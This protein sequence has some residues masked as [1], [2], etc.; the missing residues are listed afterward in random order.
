MGLAF[1]SGFASS[2]GQ[3][4]E[5]FNKQ[6]AETK[7]REA[8]IKKAEAEITAAENSN[9]LE[10]AKS[11]RTDMNKHIADQA[12][13]RKSDSKLS[14][15]ERLA[16]SNRI[17]KAALNRLDSAGKEAGKRGYTQYSTMYEEFASRGIFDELEEREG[18]L[19]TKEMAAEMDDGS[20]QINRAGDV[21]RPKLTTNSRG[22]VVEEVND[23]GGKV[24]EITS[25]KLVDKSKIFPE[26]VS[27]KDSTQLE[28][29]YTKYVARKGN[30]NV[31]F[32]DYKNKIYDPSS[33]TVYNPRELFKGDRKVKVYDDEQY[34]E[35]VNQGFSP[36]EESGSG[37]TVAQQ[38]LTDYSAYKKS[39]EI[40]GGT[41]MPFA[42]WES[43]QKASGESTV[44]RSEMGKIDTEIASIVGTSDISKVDLTQP[45][46]N[47]QRYTI[48][49][50]LRE[51]NEVIP[52]Y[53]KETIESLKGVK[54][55][56]GTL[57]KLTTS[58]VE[59]IT[60]LVDNLWSNISEFTGIG[61]AEDFASLKAAHGTLVAQVARALQGGGTLSNQDMRAAQ[62][63]AG[64]FWKSDEALAGALNESIRGQI[65]K[66]E[67]ARDA[68][69]TDKLA[70]DFE[71]GTTLKL[72]KTLYKGTSN[73]EN[74][75]I[76]LE[77][78]QQK[79]QSTK[80]QAPAKRPT[81]EDVRK[82]TPKQISDYIRQSI[83]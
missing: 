33:A 10:W 22:E 12:K 6:A 78:V 68:V 79:K 66:L 35:Y 60:G 44:L 26:D 70:F 25:E 83:K 36:V 5:N 30:E 69:T 11:F 59:D 53:S 47:K 31:T 72:L 62:K 18:F 67:S 75:I 23:S 49:Q 55:T 27:S 51:K 82:M 73:P 46:D 80:Q 40:A 34:Q 14:Q 50:K 39:A 13:L 3:G 77:D 20:V 74:G 2:F 37:I 76:T 42:K 41:P 71:Y 32:E 38:R 48:G 65:V 54:S 64:Q 24:W 19:V 63:V 52:N 43:T 1:L 81:V 61:D 4:L 57:S 16:E 17:A 56:T 15:E 28:R 7:K 9:R 29:A 21:R 58:K 8:A 45:M